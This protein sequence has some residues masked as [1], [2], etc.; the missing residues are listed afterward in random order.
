L[1]ING[2]RLFLF[3]NDKIYVPFERIATD[4]ADSPLCNIPENIV[5]PVTSRMEYLSA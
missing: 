5:L 2:L 4:M 1:K 3:G